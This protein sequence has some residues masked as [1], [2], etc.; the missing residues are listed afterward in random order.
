MVKLD[1][2]KVRFSRDGFE[3]KR[4]ECFSETVR[5]GG[6][7]GLRSVSWK[8]EPRLFGINSL[9]VQKYYVVL[10]MS[11]K[12]LR[13][14]YG[15]LL[16][17]DSIEEA[18]SRMNGLGVFEIRL[19]LLLAGTVLQAEV[20]DD[21]KL[22][23]EVMSYIHALSLFCPGRQWIA[24]YYRNGVAFLNPSESFH[25]RVSFYAKAHELMLSRNRFLCRYVNPVDFLNVLRIETQLARMR[26]LRER[27]WVREPTLEAVLNSSRNVNLE[28]F[29]K[30]ESPTPEVLIEY[31]PR[32]VKFNEVVRQVGYRELLR[33]CGMDLKRFK[34]LVRLYVKGDP[35][36]YMQIA[37]QVRAE[38]L[39]Q[40][41]MT[42]RQFGL[43]K[44]I[45][46]ALEAA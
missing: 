23:G 10:S 8:V 13:E 40:D 17:R 6:D 2:V 19:D 15:R 29:Q 25:E 30:I 44:E 42:A 41:P 45:K 5:T 46:V 26:K 34:Y 37:R 36:Y 4:K 3:A 18:V 38:M 22:S 1:A 16:S 9:V 31:E 35:S 27:F 12:V 28:S 39:S 7:G 32:T 21:L 20:T 24:Q 33:Q 14:S 11:A 43:I